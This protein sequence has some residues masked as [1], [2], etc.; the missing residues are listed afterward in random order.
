MKEGVIQKITDAWRLILTESERGD[1]GGYPW[2]VNGIRFLKIE[3]TGTGKESIFITPDQR[4]GQLTTETDGSFFVWLGKTPYPKENWDHAV[5]RQANGKPIKIEYNNLP[6]KTGWG[7]LFCG[8]VRLSSA[9]LLP[10][11]LCKIAPLDV[12]KALRKLRNG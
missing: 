3:E 12:E 1:N 10:V 9:S 11:P 7:S 4:V 2:Q 5:L 6:A 8:D